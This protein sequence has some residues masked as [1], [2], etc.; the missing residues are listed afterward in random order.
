MRIQTRVTYDFKLISTL[1]VVLKLCGFVTDD[2]RNVA[3]DEQQLTYNTKV[4]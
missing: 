4:N 1:V 2:G 3:E